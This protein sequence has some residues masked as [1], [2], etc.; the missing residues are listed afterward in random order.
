MNISDLQDDY[1]LQLAAS[2][3]FN[4]E[5]V[6]ARAV[7]DYA[8]SMDLPLFPASKFHSIP[9]QGVHAEVNGHGIMLG[10]ESWLQEQKIDLSMG[11]RN[12]LIIWPGRAILWCI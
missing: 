5:H 3:E 9:D 11:C 1:L 4:S 12:G 7:V 8:R 10:K 6:L 2:V